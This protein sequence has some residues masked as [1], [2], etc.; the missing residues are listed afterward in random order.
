[1]PTDDMIPQPY[2]RGDRVSRV[3]R[4]QAAERLNDA[5]THER[6]TRDEL[7]QRLELVYSARTY[8]DL[9]SASPASRSGA[10]SGSPARHRPRDRKSV[11]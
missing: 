8:A 11:V 2:R 4:D 1:M 7:E 9:E 10:P 5:A 6:L 3:D